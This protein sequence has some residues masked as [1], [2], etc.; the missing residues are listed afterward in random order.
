[1]KSNEGG[2]SDDNKRDSNVSNSRQKQAISRN[3]FAAASNQLTGTPESANDVGFNELHEIE[4]KNK[5]LENFVSSLDESEEKQLIHFLVE[6][7]KW[8]GL[9]PDPDTFN[10]Y[11]PE[12]QKSIISWNN[13]TIIEGSKRESKLVNEFVSHRKWAQIFSFLINFSIPVAGIVAFVLT[14]EPACLSCLGVPALSIGVNVWREHK[15]S[16]DN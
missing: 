11:S 5:T 10:K 9:L 13:A 14:K 7:R 3:D 2:V 15:D 6:E 16:E 8:S 4:K 1:M 12:I